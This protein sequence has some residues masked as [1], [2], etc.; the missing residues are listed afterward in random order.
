M[1]G[2]C[3]AC[4]NYVVLV[5]IAAMSGCVAMMPKVEE[6]HPAGYRSLVALMPECADPDLKSWSECDT[7]A[8]ML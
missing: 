8:G 3:G 1:R 4:C 2:I 7:A 5:V 6:R